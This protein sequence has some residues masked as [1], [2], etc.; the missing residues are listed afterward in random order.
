MTNMPQT[1]RGRRHPGP[2]LG[3]PVIAFA[4]LF[5][6]SLVIGPMLG[7]GTIPSP[8]SSPSVIQH[9][10]AASHTA[11]QVNGFLQVVAGIMLS[12][13]GAILLSRLQF[14]APNAPGPTIAGVG[15]ILASAVLLPRDRAARRQ[16]AA[17]EGRTA[18][19]VAT[20]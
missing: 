17:Q 2:P 12:L 4:V 5:V 6:A 8:F 15:G 7:A 20:S 11:S 18:A 9:Y 13:F 16:P 10:F 14:L 19:S 1:S 3:A